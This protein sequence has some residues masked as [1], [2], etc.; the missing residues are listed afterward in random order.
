MSRLSAWWAA[1]VIATDPNPQYSA[2][3][4]RDGLYDDRDAFNTLAA[5]IHPGGLE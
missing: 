2:L 5:H 3:D 1:N 4:Q